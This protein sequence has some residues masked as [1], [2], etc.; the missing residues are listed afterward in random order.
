MFTHR[1]HAVSG[2]NRGLRSVLKS[3]GDTEAQ[4]SEH[5]LMSH[6]AEISTQDLRS[7]SLFPSPWRPRL[8][9]VQIHSAQ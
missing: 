5:A 2:V 1:Q 9:G 6:G 7:Q 4:R 3:D 8:L